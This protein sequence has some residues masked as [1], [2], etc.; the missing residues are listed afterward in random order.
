MTTSATQFVQVDIELDFP[1]KGL[2]FFVETAV[3]GPC[4][5][6]GLP[7]AGPY[8]LGLGR[9]SREVRACGHDAILIDHCA[10]AYVGSAVC[11]SIT[12]PY[13]VTLPL[14][15]ITFTVTRAL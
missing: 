14:P 7:W 10:T 13:A 1:L 9:L 8:R 2:E 12:D 3:P 11:W 15:P 5:F 6:D 4:F